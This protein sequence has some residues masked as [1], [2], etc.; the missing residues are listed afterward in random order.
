MANLKLNYTKFVDVEMLKKKIL[1]LKS[2][3]Y[4]FSLITVKKKN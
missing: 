2:F 1:K 4:N 3:N